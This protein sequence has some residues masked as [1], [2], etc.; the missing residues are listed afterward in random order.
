MTDTRIKPSVSLTPEEIDMD[1]DTTADEQAYS[2]GSED[3]GRD[4]IPTVNLRQ[5]WWKPDWL[6]SH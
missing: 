4:H 6:D 2:S 5:S 3:I 1:D